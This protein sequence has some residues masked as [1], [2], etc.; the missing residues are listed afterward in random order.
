MSAILH[1]HATK[2]FYGA[3]ASLIVSPD[4]VPLCRTVPATSPYASICASIVTLNSRPRHWPLVAFGRRPVMV[5]CI[6]VGRV[7]V[8]VGQLRQQHAAPASG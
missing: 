8:D 1:V 3:N 6:A 7:D 2:R 4:V 5:R